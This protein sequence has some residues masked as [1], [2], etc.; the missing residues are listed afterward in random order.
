[1]SDEKNHEVYVPYV[2]RK[3]N[4]PWVRA[5]FNKKGEQLWAH[6]TDE[7]IRSAR[8]LGIPVHQYHDL[9]ETVS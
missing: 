3:P 5:G 7:E 4:R 1:M 6:A 2:Q 9:M 8:E